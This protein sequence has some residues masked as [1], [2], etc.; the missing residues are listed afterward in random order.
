MAGAVQTKAFNTASGQEIDIVDRKS[1]VSGENGT[2]EI[3]GIYAADGE[4]ITLNISNGDVESVAYFSFSTK[5]LTTKEETYFETVYDENTHTSVST[6]VTRDLSVVN[7][8]P[9][10]MPIRTPLAPYVSSVDYTVDP[11]RDYTVDT[12]NNAVPIL[13]TQINIKMCIRDRSDS[14][15]LCPGSNPGQAATKRL[16][17]VRRF[18]EYGEEAGV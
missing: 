13:A 2:F 8:D 6:Q 17:C 3:N 12:R 5:G 9:I 11:I 10:N 15:S 7:A 14:D 4:T 18:F 1:A 16:T